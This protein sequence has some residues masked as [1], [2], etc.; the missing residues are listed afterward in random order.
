MRRFF[1]SLTSCLKTDLIIPFHIHFFE[2]SEKTE[3]QEYNHMT[4][5]MFKDTKGVIRSR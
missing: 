1:N 2:S 3:Q 4:Q 5:E